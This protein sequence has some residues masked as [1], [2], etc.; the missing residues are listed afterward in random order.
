VLGRPV[1]YSHLGTRP[2]C[3][4][5]RLPKFEIIYSKFSF[6]HMERRLLCILVSKPLHSWA[7]DT[8]A[9]G[10]TCPI[11]WN[12]YCTM[13][14]FKFTSRRAPIRFGH[15]TLT[16]I[17]AHPMASLAQLA[18]GL[19]LTHTQVTAEPLH[20]KLRYEQSLHSASYLTAHP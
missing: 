1:L 8:R 2:T 12:D 3:Y 5:H 16:R 17:E 13:A 20:I 15:K 4:K 14:Q 19:R 11:A 18:N 9:Q 7:R 10:C 6:S